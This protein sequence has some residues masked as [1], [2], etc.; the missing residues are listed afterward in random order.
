MTRAELT[1]VRIVLVPL[2]VV[3]V[4]G[5]Y[6]LPTAKVIRRA[7]IRTIFHNL[8]GGHARLNLHLARLRMRLHN[9][10]GVHIRL[11][12]HL[13]CIRT[14]FYNLTGGNT[15]GYT[16]LKMNLAYITTGLHDLTAP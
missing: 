10:T 5:V 15:G 16:I 12:M 6:I 11:N 2:K 3:V 13:A 1:K 8:T 7:Y 4:L 9:L 14:K